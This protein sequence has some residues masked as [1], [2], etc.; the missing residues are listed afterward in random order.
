MPQLNPEFFVSQLFWLIVTF[1]F[2]LIFLWRISLPRISSVLEKREIKI[3]NDFETAKKLQTEAEDIQYQ[4]GQQ[5]QK[6]R[7]QTL[8]MIKDS[9]LNFQK[10]ATNDLSKLDEE[11]NKKIDNTAAI[12]DKNKNDSLKK[13]HEHILEITKLTLSKLSTVQVNQKEINESVINVKTKIMN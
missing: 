3:N 1:S 5:L 10:K 4:I 2:L 8:G 6:A 11:L 13:I 7:E 12:I 9:I